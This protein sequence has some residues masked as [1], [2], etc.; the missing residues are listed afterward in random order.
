MPVTVQVYCAFHC[1]LIA[2]YCAKKCLRGVIKRSH[3]SLELRQTEYD[4]QIGQ[5]FCILF[6]SFLNVNFKWRYLGYC[7]PA[8]SPLFGRNELKISFFLNWENFKNIFN[9]F[10]TSKKASV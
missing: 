7:K 6:L 3:I 5:K 10:L 1:A 4:W 2:C 9:C 8:L